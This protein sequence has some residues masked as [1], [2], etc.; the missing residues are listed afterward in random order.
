[1]NKAL[2]FTLF[3]LTLMALSEMAYCQEM[4]M[5]EVIILSTSDL[6]KDVK[7]E[8]FQSWINKKI[9]SPGKKRP[10]VSMHLFRADRG[11]RKG[12][13]L[14]VCTADQ[15]KNRKI[16]S[17]GSPFAAKKFSNTNANSGL[18]DFLTDPNSYIEYHLIGADKFKSLPVA[19]IL[20]IHYIKV[21]PD[22]SKE[23]EKFVVEKLHPA[24]ANVLPDMQL[25]YYKAV[26]GNYQDTNAYIT[27]F[28][29]GSMA[30]R[31][32][33]WPTGGAETEILKQRFRPLNDLATEL[34]SYLVDGSYL[35]PESG[36]AAA[37][38]ESNEWTDFTHQGVLK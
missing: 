37:Y 30:A 32:K 15:V 13:F 8:V 19:G 21:K 26:A 22:R 9:V 23:F 33:Y 12:E 29:I 31:E 3:L 10:E 25:L 36:G 1:M 6:K 27:I 24:V 16:L 18:S 38:F 28:T 7:P 4:K 35:K 14:L 5:G 11:D 17:P 34:G 2:K 20:G